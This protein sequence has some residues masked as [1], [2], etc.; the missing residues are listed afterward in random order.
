MHK[1]GK[2]KRSCEE[3]VIEDACKMILKPICSTHQVKATN[4]YSR[5]VERNIK[6]QVG[7]LFDR[8][9]DAFQN[10]RFSHKIIE[11]SHRHISASLLK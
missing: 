4:T 6:V 8:S 2:M 7:V 9:V 5:E 11:K 3:E 10:N 1:S